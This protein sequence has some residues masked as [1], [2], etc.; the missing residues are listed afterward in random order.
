MKKIRHHQFIP[1]ETLK[2]EPN[3]MA[4]DLVIVE[5]FQSESGGLTD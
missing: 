5:I 3:F 2:S 1:M 4:I